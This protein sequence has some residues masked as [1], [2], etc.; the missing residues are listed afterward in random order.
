MGGGGT[1]ISPKSKHFVW[2]GK[3]DWG[4]RAQE[5]LHNQCICMVLEG[6]LGAG[7]QNHCNLNAFVWF[8]KVGWGGVAPES[9]QNRYIYMVLEGCLGGGAPESLQN[10]CICLVLEG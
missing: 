4:G 8:G 7:H 5:S 1:R 10:Q 9:L 6:W 2:F 3:V